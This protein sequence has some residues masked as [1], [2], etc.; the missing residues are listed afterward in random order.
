M[1]VVSLAVVL[2]VAPHWRQRFLAW[3]LAFV[4]REVVKWPVFVLLGGLFISNLSLSAALHPVYSTDDVLPYHGLWHSAILGMRYSPHMLP[5]RA[6]ETIRSGGALD[7]AGYYAV[8]EYL[9]Q[10]RL[11]AEADRS[12]PDHSELHFSLD[13]YGEVQASRQHVATYLLRYC[14]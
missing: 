5:E 8:E 13:E 9:E 11:L 12:Q 1:F 14:G 3:P 4:A 6:A 7:A 10:D 2:A